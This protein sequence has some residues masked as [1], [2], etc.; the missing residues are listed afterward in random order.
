MENAQTNPQTQ[1]YVP[2][3]TV[4]AA[5]QVGQNQTVP[6]A[7]SLHQV[8]LS[9]GKI[10][11]KPMKNMQLPLILA[12]VV[13]LAGIGTGYGT[14]NLKA[15]GGLPG[16]GGGEPIQQV[17]GS[18]VN[19]GDVFGVQDEKT[20]KDSAEGYLEI[21]G[22]DGEGSHKLLRAGGEDQTVYLTS[23]ITDLDKFKGMNVKVWG[24][25][26]KGQKAGWLMDV[27]RVE[28]VNPQGSAPAEE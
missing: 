8:D 12:F 24:E 16:T 9:P 17:A 13:I 4:D 28:I 21:G 19:A 5:A 7:S 2:Q 6:A 10:N 25:T 11:K 14:A 18:D 26:F 23:S 3:S 1:S 15:N 20:F 22:L 27:G